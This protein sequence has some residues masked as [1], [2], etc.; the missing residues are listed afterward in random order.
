MV[1]GW[2]IA[3]LDPC[4]RDSGFTQSPSK[5]ANDGTVSYSECVMPSLHLT[6]DGADKLV[7]PV[8]PEGWMGD[9]V[10]HCQTEGYVRVSYLLYGWFFQCGLYG[11]RWK[12]RVY[13]LEGPG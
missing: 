1:E 5:V 12:H 11:V 7:S 6:G 2:R 3:L 13:I 9:D 4:F 8:R 10:G